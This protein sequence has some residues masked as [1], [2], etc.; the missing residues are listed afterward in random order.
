VTKLPDLT[1]LFAD[2]ECAAR[3]PV[4]CIPA[5]IGELERV[6]ATLWIRLANPC[7]GP[8]VPE[9][10]GELLTV[11]EVAERLRKSRSWVYRHA[12][13]LPFT[14]RVGRSLRFLPAGLTKYLNTSR[15][16]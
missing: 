6:K 12:G 7:S 1:A 15:R 4:E 8:N 2:P 13:R 5:V 16:P 14:R 10:N 9:V 3:L 11:E